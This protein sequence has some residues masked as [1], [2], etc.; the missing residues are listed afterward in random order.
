MKGQVST[1]LLVIVGFVLLIFIPLLVLVY[2]KAND[3]N[4]QIA[5]YQAELAVSR[6]GSLANSIGSLGVNSEVVTDVYIPPN[7]IA[8]ST[9]DAGRGS[10]IVL[11]LSTAQGQTEL[12]EVVKYPIEN[13]NPEIVG[14]STGEWVK[15]KI[16]ST[17]GES[18][19][20][21][22]RIERMN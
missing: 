8:L 13:P 5:S 11:T 18:G 21:Y 6:L 10:E 15:I 1:E 17:T 14:E 4:Q 16:T 12:V 19:E 20:A 3:A 2:M 7:T 9:N 22:I